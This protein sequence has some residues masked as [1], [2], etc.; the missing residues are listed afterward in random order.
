MSS[1][2]SSNNSSSNKN[3]NNLNHLSPL[4]SEGDAAL[5]ELRSMLERLLE[6]SPSSSSSSSFLRPPSLD[7]SSQPDNGST[8]TWATDDFEG[9]DLDVV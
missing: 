6:S 8:S 1:N 9:D 2:N 7:S 4:A 5:G 3:N